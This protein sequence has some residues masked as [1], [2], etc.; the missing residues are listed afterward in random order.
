MQDIDETLQR[1]RVELGKIL[2][3][4]IDEKNT[5]KVKEENDV[6]KIS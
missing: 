6:L 4:L 2:W 3:D 1:V 5:M